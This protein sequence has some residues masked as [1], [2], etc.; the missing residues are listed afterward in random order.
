MVEEAN[1]GASCRNCS[2]GMDCYTTGS[3]RVGRCDEATIQV[4]VYFLTIW[5]VFVRSI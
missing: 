4:F 2:C 5:V 1:Y 3:L